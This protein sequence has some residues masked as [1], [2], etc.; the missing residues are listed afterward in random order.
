MWTCPVC[1]RKFK[2]TNQYHICTNKDVGELF[3]DKSDEL[4]LAFDRIANEVMAWKPNYM[5]A[6]TNAVV[7]TNHKAWLIVRPMQKELDVKFYH[8]DEIDADW[9]KRR[10]KYPNKY[11]YHLR[12]ADECQI[13]RE[14]MQLLRQ[15]YDYALQ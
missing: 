15:G 11:A 3:M 5:G 10:V 4:V 2:N 12:V 13:D 7:F 8:R 1:D 6:S 9:I 14:F